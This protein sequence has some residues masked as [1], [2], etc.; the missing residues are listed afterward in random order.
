MNSNFKYLFGPVASRRF[1]RSLGVDLL[2]Q[3][4]CSFNCVFCE[5]GR[6]SLCTIERKEYVPTNEIL[7]ELRRWKNFNIPTDVITIA[8]SGEPTLHT[9][10]G[11]IIEEINSWKS[12]PTLLLTNSSLMFLPEVR[13][14]AS[15]AKIVKA[16]FSAFDQKSFEVICR[17]NPALR[18]DDIF[19]G[20]CAF[21]N[22]FKGKLWIEVF[23]VPGLND[24]P[25]TISKIAQLVKKFCPDKVQ[26][27]T[28]VRPA[29]EDFVKAAEQSHLQKLAALFEPAAE[30]VGVFKV[31]KL[32][33]SSQ[34]INTISSKE[35][36]L[37]LLKRRPCTSAEIAMALNTE[38]ESVLKLLEK[39]LDKKEIFYET[40][41]SETFYYV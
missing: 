40:R 41:G 14:D 7:E 36:I 10:F 13:K 37:Q 33:Q 30:V 26:L 38:K 20:L 29:A 3:K 2:P 31:E 6:T 12:H 24:S 35:A 32:N 23:I 28:A 25:E 22:E 27:N 39:M 9:G 4:V 21:R 34:I 17:P 16:S 19:E 1:G 11:K 18:F 15:K 5:V 8:G